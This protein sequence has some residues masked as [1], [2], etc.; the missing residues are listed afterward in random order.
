M[1]AVSVMASGHIPGISRLGSAGGANRLAKRAMLGRC[2]FATRRANVGF[3]I[4]YYMPAPLGIIIGSALGTK[5]T[6]VP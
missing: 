4:H 6:N 5:M 2:L 1:P 3:R